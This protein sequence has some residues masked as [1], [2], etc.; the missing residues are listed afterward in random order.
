MSELP[1]LEKWA[2]VRRTLYETPEQRAVFNSLGCS[3]CTLCKP[4]LFET[5]FEK[6]MRWLAN[7]D[8]TAA[9]IVFWGDEPRIS[10]KTKSNCTGS[11]QLNYIMGC[12]TR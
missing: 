4:E 2:R 7:D 9:H 10:F 5:R 3:G 8:I 12:A 1:N 6:L 11:M